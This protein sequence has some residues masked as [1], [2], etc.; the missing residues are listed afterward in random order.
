MQNKVQTV[1]IS[2]IKFE[3]KFLRNQYTRVKNCTV[4]LFYVVEF[5]VAVIY[6]CYA[7]SGP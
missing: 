5:Q 4:Y 2:D 6:C 3:A 7:S 1:Q